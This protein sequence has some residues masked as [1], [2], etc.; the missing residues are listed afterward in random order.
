MPAYLLLLAALLSR[1]IPHSGWFGFTAVGGSLLYFGAKRAKWLEMLLP[2][3][4]F[5]GVDYYLTTHVYAYD[6]HWQEYLVTWGWTAAAIVLGRILLARKVSVPRVASAAVLGPT[7]FF[8]ASN[9]AVWAGS[10]Y[11][12]GMYAPD[13]SG[14]L[15]CLAAGLP[16]YGRD[17][18]STGLVLTIAFGAPVAIRSYLNS[19]DSAGQ[20]TL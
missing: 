2:I 17:L 5:A 3:A 10:H 1:V 4:A 9:Y 7:S 15:T 16:F 8:L 11:P 14:L 6:F 12:G 19:R 20:H 13:F 18:I